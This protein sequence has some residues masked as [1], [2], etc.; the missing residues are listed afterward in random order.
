MSKSGVKA[1]HDLAA[2]EYLLR[3]GGGLQP[4]GKRDCLGRWFPHEMEY[5]ECCCSVTAPTLAH[6]DSFL[7]HC[8]TQRHV[9]HLYGITEREM[10][11]AV[12][13][14]RRKEQNV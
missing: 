9:A 8:K 14:L 10:R 2:I 7:R 12:A 1:Y 11:N 4:R 5:K 6:P 3:R 13:R